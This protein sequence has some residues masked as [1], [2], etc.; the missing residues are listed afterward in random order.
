[1]YTYRDGSKHLVP[2]V[3]YRPTIDELYHQAYKDTQQAYLEFLNSSF[4]TLDTLQKPLT[5]L[6]V[7]DIAAPYIE[8]IEDE[9]TTFK[10]LE[11]REDFEDRAR[12]KPHAWRIE[13]KQAYDKLLTN[14]Y[15]ND[16]PTHYRQTS[17]NIAMHCL[18]LSEA[19]ATPFK[20]TPESASL[21][22]AY[23]KTFPHSLGA[24]SEQL[25]TLILALQKAD[26]LRL[27]AQNAKGV[28]VR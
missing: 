7:R 8:A 1:M 26:D 25:N 15:S 20:T 3:R 16:L 24:L 17:N 6:K 13:R 4:A 9:I 21:I 5:A 2:P 11:I 10:H 19:L 14:Y 22:D 27:H 18:R 12:T 28:Y 23:R